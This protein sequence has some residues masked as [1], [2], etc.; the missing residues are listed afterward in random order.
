MELDFKSNFENIVTEQN[1]SN[2]NDCNIDVDDQIDTDD[3]ELEIYDRFLSE[4]TNV[5]AL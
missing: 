5:T 4:C 3:E 2:I 1:G